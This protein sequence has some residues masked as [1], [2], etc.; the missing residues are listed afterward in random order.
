MK[1]HGRW[2]RAGHALKGVLRTRLGLF[3]GVTGLGIVAG[4]AYGLGAPETYRATMTLFVESAGSVPAGSGATAGLGAGLGLDLLRSERVAQRVILD[5]RLAEEPGLRAHYLEGVETGRSPMETLAQ[6]LSKHVAA[7]AEGEGGVIRVSATLEDPALAARV[8]NGYAQAWREVGSELRTAA[9]RNGI[10]RAH[11]DLVALRARLGE[12]V[13]RRGGSAPRAGAESLADRQFAQ[14]SRLATRFLHGSAEPETPAT[15]ALEGGLPVADVP[16]APGESG[17]L[18]AAAA[19]AGSLTIANDPQ[20]PKSGII[21]ADEEI[22]LAQQSLERAEERLAR[23]SSEDVGAALP[24]YVLHEAEVPA[25]STKP[26][27]GI[28]ILA[29]FV[30]GLILACLACAVAEVTDRR[31][32]SA[33]DVAQRLGMIVLGDLP[34]TARSRGAARPALRLSGLGERA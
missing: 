15:P 13:A 21:S 27:T 2:T 31:I 18:Q 1:R 3:S 22:R 16:A 10:E 4:L 17:A 9:V 19:G 25:A 29:G 7:G 24:V 23:L 6:F 32:R 34:A 5:Q 8:A 30:I 33:S 11:Q 12:A 20:G 14:L 28:C 26:S